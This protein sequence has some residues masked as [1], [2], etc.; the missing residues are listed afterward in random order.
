MGFFVP[1][2]WRGKKMK[3]KKNLKSVM[4]AIVV[5]IISATMVISS[6]F[7]VIHL[8]FSTW[9]PGIDYTSINWWIRK[10]LYVASF[11][12]A[13]DGCNYLFKLFEKV[14]GEFEKEPYDD[15]VE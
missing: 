11:G 1:Q 15:G 6:V 7:L 4:L 5:F 14:F 13:V 9:L 10:F 2:P 3:K 8:Y 12:V